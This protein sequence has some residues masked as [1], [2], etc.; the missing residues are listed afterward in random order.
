MVIK[1]LNNL[2]RDELIKIIR[3]YEERFSIIK[4]ILYFE[5][6]Y[7]SNDDLLG[8]VDKALPKDIEP[9]KID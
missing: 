7:V 6:G 1:E 8:F 3:D 2:P 4:G 9:K 5:Y